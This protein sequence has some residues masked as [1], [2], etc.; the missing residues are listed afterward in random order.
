VITKGNREAERFRDEAG[1]W[2]PRSERALLFPSREVLPFEPLSPEPG[3]AAGRMA[4]LTALAAGPGRPLVVAPLEAALQ[5]LI[6]RAKLLLAR[7][8]VHRGS[9]IAGDRFRRHLVQWGY[10]PS[11]RVAAPGEFSQRGGIIDFFP[12]ALPSPVRLEL[13]GDDVDSIHAFDAETQRNTAALERVPVLPAREVFLDGGVLGALKKHLI[14][15]EGGPAGGESWL[16]Q[17]AAG[18]PA[19]STTAPRCCTRARR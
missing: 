11:E 3:I 8:D 7:L 10:R 18:L 1:F 13:F 4:T 17:Q 15:P 6:P 5:F 9:T 14:V 19:W 12:P 2:L 16:A